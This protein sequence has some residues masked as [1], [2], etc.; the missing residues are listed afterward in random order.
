MACRA[1]SAWWTRG[2]QETLF[3][4]RGVVRAGRN[5]LIVLELESAAEAV[6]AFVPEPRLG[7]TE[8]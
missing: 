2:P 3:V 4:P 8:F 7:H 5:E 1:P 6:A